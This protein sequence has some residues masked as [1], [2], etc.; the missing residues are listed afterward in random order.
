MSHDP[1]LAAPDRTHGWLT[2]ALWAWG[3][4]A[5]AVSVKVLVQ[6]E[7]H[8]VYPVFAQGARHWWRD[9]PLY[10]DYGD[11][12]L[13]LFRYSPTFAVAMTPLALLPDWLGGVL[14]NLLSIGV[15]LLALRRVVQDVLPGAWPPERMGLLIG[16]TLVNSV[17]GI[18]SGQNNT[19]LMACVLLAC[20]A[21]ARRRFW[22]AAV[23]LAAAAFIKVWPLALVMLLAVRWPWALGARFLAAAA[24]L[25]A[26]PF[27]TRP[28]PMVVEQ[29]GRWWAMLR[30]TQWVRWGGYRDA[31]TVLEG[32]GMHVEPAAYRAM[33]LA[34]AAVV[35]GGCLWQWLR[36]RSEREWLTAVLGAWLAWQMLFG[37]GTERLTY[38]V[39]APMTAWAV[40]ESL[41][42]RR[43]RTLAIAAWSMTGLLG[44]GGIERLLRPFTAAATAVAPL[45]AVVFVLWL[46]QHRQSPESS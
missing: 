44:S 45:G 21:I 42:Q 28:W 32:T 36:N 24:G 13:D 4:L 15:F 29:Y 22:V 14:W 20:S 33:Q 17:R 9:R 25:A 7:Q 23:L 2:A 27:L 12:D 30:D 26:M 19:L 16:L 6:P 31:W 38:M 5:V 46:V 34:G 3:V 18:W 37:P 1:Q 10:A 39:V 41:A 8:T 40:V 35:L 11:L 43:G